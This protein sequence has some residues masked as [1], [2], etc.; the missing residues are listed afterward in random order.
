MPSSVSTPTATLTTSRSPARR[1]PRSPTVTAVEAR[2]GT[3][4]HDLRHYY[5][6]LLIRHGESVKT[7]QRR[8]GHATPAETLD[9]YAYLWPGL[10]R[11]HPRSDRLRPAVIT[12]R[13]ARSPAVT[14]ESTR[15]GTG[16][17]GPLTD[18]G[19]THET[20]AISR[21]VTTAG[22]QVDRLQRTI[23]P[24]H[25]SRV[26]CHENDHWEG[27]RSSQAWCGRAGL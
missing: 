14:G 24:S 8:L 3:G 11:T 1:E 27:F 18:R 9:T 23:N 2:R 10:R 7:V 21:N 16:R 17:P 19:R 5:A 20:R 6:S 13:A 4:F 12:P 25:R 15:S 22:S 26:P